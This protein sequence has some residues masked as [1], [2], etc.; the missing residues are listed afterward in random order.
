MA[1]TTTGTCKA[2]MSNLR[3]KGLEFG[4]TRREVMDAIVAVAGST[5]E[6]RDRYMTELKRN[7]FIKQKAPDKFELNHEAAEAEEDLKLIGD[8]T[9]RVDMIEEKIKVL[10]A[11]GQ[12]TIIEV[13]D[14]VEA[15]I[16][17]LEEA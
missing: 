13:A 14:D 16:K 1:R 3:G 17:A 12:R 7:R 11:G 4:A 2:I 6:T 9:I 8:L 5:R 10:E 15:R